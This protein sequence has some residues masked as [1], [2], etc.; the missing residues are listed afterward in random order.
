MA[1]WFALLS[2]GLIALTTPSHAQQLSDIIV[3]YPEGNVLADFA[4]EDLG[5][6]YARLGLHMVL[7]P[8]P[9]ARSLEA[10]NS[11]ET[12]AEAARAA[13]I[14]KLYPNL[15]KVPE[16]VLELEERAITTGAPLG[17][18]G[19]DSLKGRHLCVVIGDKTVEDRTRGFKRET[20]RTLESALKMLR[21]GRCDTMVIYP[22]Q[23]LEIDQLH[24]G[25]FCLG[26][27]VLERVPLYHFVNK[28][29]ED[30]IPRLAEALHD[31]RADGSTAR[32][33]APILQ[34]IEEA[35]ARNSCGSRI[36]S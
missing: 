31:L 17:G 25:P 20:A 33:L 7:K 5:A 12:D 35:K 32:I 21:A 29:H 2:F 28:R 10:A 14:A 16:P 30:L 19:W 3:S 26:T 22:S 24:L 23:W 11:G 4:R 6:A 34:Q 18:K 27:G 36:T 9:S 13:G 8:L 15:R 1:K